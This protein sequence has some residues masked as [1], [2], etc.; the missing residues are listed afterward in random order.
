MPTNKELIKQVSEAK[1]ALR[2]AV[3]KI[4]E[5]EEKEI[6]KEVLNKVAVGLAKTTDNKYRVVKI[7]YSPETGAAMVEE[8]IKPKPTDDS[9]A[10][11][12]RDAQKLFFDVIV[13]N[14]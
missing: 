14:V 9:K 2:E 11:A 3:A 6:D 4:K 7:A 8:I 10:V 12:T 13:P 5:L 1:K